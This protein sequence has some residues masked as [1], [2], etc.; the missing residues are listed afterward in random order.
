MT[1]SVLNIIN[2]L[3]LEERSYQLDNDSEAMFILVLL[4]EPIVLLGDQPHF[5]ENI[6]IDNKDST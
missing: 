3:H 5:Q 2:N 6:V 1:Y 4:S